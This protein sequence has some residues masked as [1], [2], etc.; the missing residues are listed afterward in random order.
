LHPAILGHSKRPGANDRDED[1][2]DADRLF[3]HAGK[4]DTFFP[5]T[6]IGRGMLNLSVGRLDQAKF[7]FQ[8]TL[9]QCGP[10]MPSLLGMAAVLY[11]ERDY[12]GA[13]QMYAEAIRKYPKKSGASTR[14]GFGL[15]SY[16]LGQVDR[17][18]AAFARALALDPECVEAMVGAAILDMAALDETAKDFSVRTEKAIKM[19]SMANLLDHSNA[20]V[21]NH[22]A[23]HYFW[24]WT[25]VPGTVEVT[26]GSVL[27]KGS[28]SIPLEP[29]ERI[30]IGPR[31]ETTVVED[32]SMDDDE[33]NTSFRIQDP[34]KGE[35]S[36][37]LKVWKKDYDRV[38]TLAKG[39]YGSTA[40]EHIQA[41]S[42]FFLARVYHVREENDNAVKFYERACKLAPDLA[43]ARFGLAQTLVVKGDFKSAMEH[44]NTLLTTTSGNATDALALLGLLEVRTGK[45]FDEGMSHLHKA[46]E[47]DPLNPDL[48]VLEALALQQNKSTF[49]TSLLRYKKAIDLMQRKGVKVPYEIYTN[50]G[51]LCH[52]TKKYDEALT[53]YKLALEALDQSGSM[54]EPS[55]ESV[56]PSG[57]RIRRS[58]N[59]MFCGFVDSLVEVEPVVDNAKLMKVIT[60]SG[61]DVAT[62]ALRSGDHIR[63]NKDFASV[64]VKVD[65]SDGVTS[66]ELRDEYSPSENVEDGRSGPL[67]V[68]VTRENRYLEIPEAMTVAFNVARLHE[69]TG[70]ILASIELHKAILKRNPT[71]VNSSLRLACIA[72]DCGC[73]KECSDWLKVAAQ[74]APGNPE[75]LTLIGNLHLSLCDWKPASSVFE[76]LL[77]KKIPNVEAYSSLSLGNIFFANLNVPGRYSKNLQYASDYYKGILKKDPTNTY[78]ANGMATVLAERGEIFKAKEAFNRVREVSSDSIADALLNL[79]HIYL[80]QKK[81]P[82]AL[83]MYQ[84][85][86]KRTEDGATP[87]TS[88]SRVEDVVDVLLYIAFAYFDWARHTELYNDANAAPA[89]GRYKKAMQHLELAISKQSK[90]DV[91]L[92]YDLC[93]AKLQAANCVLQKTTRN[94]P[95]TMEE[96]EEALAGLQES[97]EVVEQIVKDK[98]DGKKVPIPSSTLQNFLTH[99]RANISSAQSHLEDEKKRAEEA[100]EENEIRRKTAEA[101]RK[102]EELKDAIKKHEEAKKQEERDQKAEAAMRKVEQLQNNWQQEQQA[103][104]AEKEKKSK[105]RTAQED[106]FI[107]EEGAPSGEGAPGLF[108]DSDDESSD[109]DQGGSGGEGKNEPEKSPNKNAESSTQKDLFGDSD[110]E[111]EED[112]SKKAASQSKGIFGDSDE[113]DDDKDDKAIS[114]EKKSPP[115]QALF[116]DS[117]DE[118]ESPSKGTEDAA[119]TKTTDSQALFD[120]S[121]E[122]S[123]EELIRPDKRQRDSEGDQPQKKRRV[124]EDD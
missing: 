37:S 90:K 28:Q 50:G 15:A 40:V 19:M 39:A 24:K 48:L 10:V 81:H 5:M 114:G 75:V 94:I 80:A 32:D 99:C 85:Y 46:I 26:D 84:N 47:L 82:E 9:K 87:I 111:E 33:E 71:Y 97:L 17:A 78:A 57:G 72:V 100:E 54:R 65:N 27:V 95:R 18:K 11:G 112:S 59:D 43:P 108:D 63:L 62:L 16:R 89:D 73:L 3:T 64:I 74:S 93:M 31:F 4:V 83:Q 106:D 36:S 56:G 67:T 107:T 102:E 42:L 49:A 38:I 70:R 113:D 23:N 6:W 30:R 12:K 121:D 91:V 92:R 103:Q 86:M 120:D 29:G 55:L 88:K 123:D 61:A 52:E 41:E 68:F 13:Q 79:G 35:N 66:I 44:L 105:K 21:Q 116:D 118:D 119:A 69:A 22:L 20:M 122:E 8:T 110:D 60:P 14:V 25:P 104:Q 115:K 45:K 51:V 98:N 2:D 1:R 109:D 117:D 53:M 58:E 101:E 77:V 7:F 96:V 76:G 124:L 34:W